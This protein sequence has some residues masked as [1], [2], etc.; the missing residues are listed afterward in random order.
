MEFYNWS[1]KLVKD[2]LGECIR[3]HRGSLQVHFDVTDAAIASNMVKCE[4]TFLAGVVRILQKVFNISTR[5]I[6][7]FGAE[8]FLANVVVSDI[9]YVTMA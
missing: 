6:V 1:D 8:I 2:Y 3:A 5:I 9:M 4:H 7:E